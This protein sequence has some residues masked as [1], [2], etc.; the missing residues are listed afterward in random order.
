MISQLTPFC[1]V[2]W[3]CAVS[4]QTFAI[5]DRRTEDRYFVD[6]ALIYDYG[7]TIGVYGIAVYNVLAVHADLKTQSSFPSYQTIADEIGCSRRKVIA[8]IRQL[9]QLHIVRK[10][11]R[12]REPEDLDDPDDHKYHTSNLYDL[13]DKSCWGSA[14]GAPGVVQDVHQGSAQ[15]A[16][17]VV[18]DVH[19]NNPHL[20]NPHLSNDEESHQQIEDNLLSLR[21]LQGYGLPPEWSHRILKHQ[22]PGDSHHLLLLIGYG[23]SRK[24]ASKMLDRLGTDGIEKWKAYLLENPKEKP[25]AYL[26]TAVMVN[27]DIEPPPLA[28]SYGASDRDKA[29]RQRFARNTCGNCLRERVLCPVCGLCDDCCTCGVTNE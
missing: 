16:P 4:E 12:L 1:Q 28:S 23:G 3:G 8:A 6:N 14:Q 19:P 7:A 13:L 22:R 25:F 17:G 26:W 29:E 2:C 11:T 5:R 18:Q 20:N 9:E 27:G 15:G 21:D 24:N 10:T